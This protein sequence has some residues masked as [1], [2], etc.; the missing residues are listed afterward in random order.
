MNRKFGI[1]WIWGLATLAIAGIVAAI[2]YHAGQATQIVTTAPGGVIYRGYDGFGFF[3]FFGFLWFLL[4]AFLLFGLFRRGM[5][6]GRG[7]WGGGGYG[8]HWHQHPHEH[9]GTTTPTT[10]PAGGEPDQPK[11]V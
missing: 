1:G 8:G 3:P 4:I 2:A 7:H 11:S 6:W 10:P 5:G 9:G